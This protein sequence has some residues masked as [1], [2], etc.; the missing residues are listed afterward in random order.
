MAGGNECL[1][2]RMLSC[3]TKM[4]SLDILLLVPFTSR[5]VVD[6]FHLK[7]YCSLHL[8]KDVLLFLL[9]KDLLFISFT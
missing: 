8:P 3:F 6:S 5:F 1:D 9:L 7:T 2:L 4:I